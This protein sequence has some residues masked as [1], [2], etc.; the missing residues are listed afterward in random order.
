MNI[1]IKE[2]LYL[3]DYNDNVLDVLFLSTDKDTPGQAY[4]INIK[5]NNTGF[6]DLTFKMPSYIINEEGEKVINPKLKVLRR[7]VEGLEDRDISTGLIPLSK[8]RYNRVVRYMGEEIIN[9]PGP[10]GTIV[11]YPKNAGENPEDYIIEDYTMDYIIQPLDKARQSLKIDL[12]YT[13]IDFPRFNLSKKKLGFTIDQ[14]TLTTPELSL[15]GNTPMNVPGSVQYIPWTAELAQQYQTSNY[16]SSAAALNS[17]KQPNKGE[18]YY[19]TNAP[20]TGYYQYN[21]EGWVKKEAADFVTWEP[22]P[23]SGGYPLDDNSIKKLISQTEFTN[24]ILATVFY[25]P[26]VI[27]SYTSSTGVEMDRKTARFEGVTYEKGSFITLTL[28]NLYDGLELQWTTDQKVG[29]VAWDWNYLEPNKLY[30]N[31]NNACNLLRYILK[32]T[33]WSV[34]NDGGG[35]FI[36][37]SSSTPW[38]DAG[39]G[40]GTGEEGQYYIIRENSPVGSIRPYIYTIMQ[41]HNGIPQDATRELLSIVNT[42]ENDIE[43][44]GV[45]Y[46]VFIEPKE[47]SRTAEGALGQIELMDSQYSLNVSNANCY[48]AITSEAKLFNLYPVFDCINKTVALRE[49]AGADYSLAYR[50]GRNLKTSNIKIDGEKVIT[51]L[52]VTGGTDAQGSANINIGEAI[53]VINGVTPTLTCPKLDPSH[54]DSYVI[55]NSEIF[56]NMKIIQEEAWTL[57]TGEV[58]TSGLNLAQKEL[59]LSFPDNFYERFFPDESSKQNDIQPML[60]ADFTTKKIWLR[61]QGNS[62][63]TPYKH[64][65]YIY[66]SDNIED[67]LDEKKQLYKADLTNIKIR[68]NLKTY[69]DTFGNV[70]TAPSGDYA[71]YIKYRKTNIDG[72]KFDTYNYLYQMGIG[73][74]GYHLTLDNEGYYEI[75]E[76]FNTEESFVLVGPSRVYKFDADN[77]LNQINTDLFTPGNYYYTEEITNG[78]TNRR[79]YYCILQNELQDISSNLPYYYNSALNKLNT[80]AVGSYVFIVLG[81]GSASVTIQN[82]GISYVVQDINGNPITYNDWLINNYALR[83]Q[84]DSENNI[85]QEVELED[86]WDPNADEYLV[87]R[88]PYGTSYIYNFKYLYDNE[89]MTKKQILDIYAKNYEI[90]TINIDFFNK[91]NKAL[92]AARKAYWDAIN[93]LELYE[94]KGDAQLETLMSQYWKDPAKASEDRFS[95][96]PYRPKGEII[97]DDT[98]HMYKANIDYK[99]E[100]VKTVYFNIFN[101][102]GC[103]YLYPN[104]NTGTANAQNP[105]TEG[106]YHVVAKALGWEAFKTMQLPINETFT[107][108][109]DVVD[110]SDTVSNYNKIINNMKLYYWKAKIAGI[111]MDNALTVVE[112]LEELFDQWQESLNNIER[113]LQENYGQ[114]IIEGSYNNTEQPYANLLLQDGLK[115]SDIYA[116]PDITYGVNVVDASGLIEYRIS[117]QLIAN[118]LVKKLHSLGQ[119]VPKVG[120][121]VSILDEEMG[122]IKVKG[123]ITTITRRID[124][125]YQNNLTIDTSYTDADELVGQII[126]A[127]N[128]VLNN[129]DIYGRASI[130]NS[131]GELQTGTVTNAL[132]TGKNSVSITSTNGKIVVDDNGLTATN[133]E[134]DQKLMRYNGTGVLGSSN[135][136]ITWRSLMTQDGINAN[137][138]DAGTINSTKVSITNGQY[139]TVILDGSGL[140]VKTNPGRNY[141]LGYATNDGIV[142]P[143][144]SNVS[145]FVGKDANNTGIGYFD[146]YIKATKG[147]DIAGWTLSSTALWK[148]GTQSNPTYYLGSEPISATMSSDTENK[149]YILKIAD[150]FG[151]TSTGDLWAA[152]NV[153]IKGNGTSKIGPWTITDSAYYNGKSSLSDNS[154]GVYLGVDGIALG[155]NNNFV[156]TDAGKLTAKSGK[157]GGWSINDKNIEYGTTT[158]L[159]GSNGKIATKSLECRGG[160]FSIVNTGWLSIGRVSTHPIVSGLNVSTTGGISFRSGASVTNSGTWV[161]SINSSANGGIEYGS[162]KG[163]HVFKGGNITTSNDIVCGTLMASQINADS[164]SLTLTSVTATTVN[165]T[166]LEASNIKPNGGNKTGQTGQFWVDGSSLV[167]RGRWIAVYNGIICGHQTSE[168]SGLSKWN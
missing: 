121:Y 136:G 108:P 167:S 123:L 115:A 122:L 105:E 97:V 94:S 101:T 116:V 23:Q 75:Q 99:G 78:I 84:V 16:V 90:N 147:G 143:Q 168:Y 93:N 66:C 120:D 107:K 137:Y 35:M 91:Y 150:K 53:R 141:E 19:V 104:S 86:G 153:Y 142:W 165:A 67:Y 81:D 55:N 56:N 32:N 9:F 60:L 15:W 22:N 83:V 20:D 26:V 154:D 2:S 49:H 69:T 3:L 111:D 130:I 85:L 82:N 138:I 24:G 52:Y 73:Y 11:Q 37:R 21:G 39:T 158:V 134:D 61:Y 63:N 33:N 112:E 25:W 72:Q 159:N 29:N 118:D 157:I 145:V 34:A 155:A 156:V 125:P 148:G 163:N 87:G 128:T 68:R 79:Y 131:K 139:D 64:C 98:K 17:V 42:D 38:F 95:A 59:V 4:E 1:F 44:F 77:A 58:I 57:L 127:T 109:S 135:G 12:T 76:P 88:S 110:A 117:Q 89:W 80:I 103:N 27:P 149:N 48:N 92:E 18:V 14:N 71:E 36:P 6:S 74:K 113:Y 144:N 102:D 140:T 151:V 45:K 161:A 166:T 129:K 164:G 106:Q 47:V 114:Y 65:F 28:Y 162:G 5:E 132:S 133:P 31:P 119:I 62:D 41:F 43:N 8:V 51:K 10:N 54:P 70:N 7:K 40:P 96:F 50:A 46:D 13:A 160:S 124:D 152:G 146:G 126:T 30:L 100:V